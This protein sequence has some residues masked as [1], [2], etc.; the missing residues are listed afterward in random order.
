MSE[1]KK[2][3]AEGL[4]SARSLAG[5][6]GVG[7]A[8]EEGTG[9]PAEERRGKPR[10]GRQGWRATARRHVRPR[11]A[12]VATRRSPK[13]GKG[14]GAGVSRRGA[15]V[16]GRLGDGSLPLELER[17]VERAP[18]LPHGCLGAGAGA[19]QPQAQGLVQQLV[20]GKP[21]RGA[22]PSVGLTAAVAAGRGRAPR[23]GSRSRAQA[24]SRRGAQTVGPAAAAAAVGGRGAGGRRRKGSAGRAQLGFPQ[25]QKPPL[26]VTRGV[27]FHVSK[28]Q[29]DTFH[30]RPL[31]TAVAN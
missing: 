16:P 19:G 7:G 20:A 10:P 8:T 30:P 12:Q 4:T 2:I 13:R 26:R 28:C 14:W 9:A 21:G 6:G 24:S 27:N 3:H 25:Y 18:E 17:H 29:H 5:Q 11:P 1:S 23:G 31:H 22:A 15:H